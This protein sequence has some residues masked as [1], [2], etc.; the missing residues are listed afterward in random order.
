[1]YHLATLQLTFSDKRK[2]ELKAVP[3]NHLAGVHFMNL[4][5]GQKNS[6]QRFLIEIWTKFH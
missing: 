4:Y 5:F 6:N 1:M 3:S 2:K